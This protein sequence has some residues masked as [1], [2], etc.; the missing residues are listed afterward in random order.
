VG[1]CGHMLSWEAKNLVHLICP[2]IDSTMHRLL[3]G[4][5]IFPFSLKCAQI[6]QCATTPVLQSCNSLAAEILVTVET[7]EFTP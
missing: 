6:E 7:E 3:W 1:F 5:V 4:F 2:D